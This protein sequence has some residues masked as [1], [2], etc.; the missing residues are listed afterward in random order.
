MTNTIKQML[1]DPNP[2]KDIKQ[3]KCSQRN[4]QA[5]R[6]NKDRV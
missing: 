5:K 4:R 6:G 3:A 2:V 1:E